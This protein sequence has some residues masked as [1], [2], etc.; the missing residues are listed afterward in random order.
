[1]NEQDVRPAGLVRPGSGRQPVITVIVLDADFSGALAYALDYALFR[2]AGV[3]AV[4]VPWIPPVASASPIPVRDLVGSAPAALMR[5][6][7]SSERLVAQ[8][9]AGAAHGGLVELR[10][11]TYSPL[12]EVDGDGL[13]VRFSDPHDWSSV[14]RSAATG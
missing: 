10:Q 5:I 3:R 7:A 9:G 4:R 14:H 1:M 2:P 8:C 11:N 13:V 12:V 6:S